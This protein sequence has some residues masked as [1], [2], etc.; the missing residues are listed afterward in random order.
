MASTMID[1]LK[2]AETFETAGFEAQKARAL[3]AA[4]GEANAIVRE[5][6]VTK[7]Y[8]DARLGE[9]KGELK[10]AI[11]EGQRSTLIWIFGMLVTLGGLGFAAYNTIA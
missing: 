6:L 1:T 3:A 9:L 10:T 4:M 7:D 5:D 2:F 8:L 11:S